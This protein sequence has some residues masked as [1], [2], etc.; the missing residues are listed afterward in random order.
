MAAAS[1]FW[2]SW[3]L[4]PAPGACC[5]SLPHGTADRSKWGRQPTATEAPT[6]IPA[7]RSPSLYSP[8]QMAPNAARA[9]F[10]A[11]C[12][13]PSRHAIRVHRRPSHPTPAAHGPLLPKSLA[14]SRRSF[15][16]TARAS[17][18][19]GRRRSSAAAPTIPVLKVGHTLPPRGDYLVTFSE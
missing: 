18:K 13:P 16:T 17:A 8:R 4:F 15:G 5:P 10:P 6:R 2:G 3:V 1:T 11:L 12:F 14:L 7:S 19:S 9:L